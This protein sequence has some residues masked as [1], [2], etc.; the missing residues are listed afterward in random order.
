VLEAA[1]HITRAWLL[2]SAG[3][4]NDAATEA[5]IAAAKHANPADLQALE[6]AIAKG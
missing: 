6:Q 4:R 2:V 3:R 5:R 1:H